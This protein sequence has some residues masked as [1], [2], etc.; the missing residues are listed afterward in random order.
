MAS[1]KRLIL[2]IGGAKCG[3]SAIQAY[4][5][6][7]RHAL[8][9]NKV[10]VPS[11][12]LDMEG[13]FTGDQIWFFQN[14]R[15]NE[16]RENVLMRRFGGLKRYMD[17]FG[18][19]TLV[20]SA[21][22]ISNNLH[23]AAEFAR[24]LSEFETH[25]VFY[26][27]RQDDYLISAWQ[28][29][30]L[31]QFPSLEVYIDQKIGK[32]PDWNERTLPWAEAFGDDRVSVRV[33]RRDKLVNQNVVDD[34][35]ATTGL[36][37]TDCVAL[38]GLSNPSF[39]EHLGDMLHRIQDVFKSPHDNEPYGTL[40]RLIGPMAFKPDSRSHLFSL[41]ERLRILDAFADS[42]AALKARFLPELGDAPLFEMPT[43]DNVREMSEIEKL[44]AEQDLLLRAVLK[45]G[46]LAAK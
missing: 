38:E 7:N 21:E 42:N 41:E 9:R 8:F 31:K 11:T 3:S 13:D 33:F 37:V 35:I 14:I 45:L 29:W 26:V 2:H 46:S 6:K 24:V 34:F 27:R 4:L 43:E 23:Y 40:A 18:S 25:V 28:Q 32:Y 10:L 30:D 1:K 39:N 20:V 17:R 5:A 12:K 19:D 44:R 15:R 16:D 22:N 36:D